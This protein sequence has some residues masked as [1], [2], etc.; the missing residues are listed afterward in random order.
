[1]DSIQHRLK[2]V[3]IRQSGPHGCLMTPDSRPDA[4]AQI[5]EEAVAH[6]SVVVQPV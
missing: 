4:T 6:G 1:M 5:G 2:L 3:M